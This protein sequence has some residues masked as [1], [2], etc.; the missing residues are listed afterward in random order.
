[1]VKT[2]TIE[3][4][5]DT[6]EVEIPSGRVGAIQMSI[7][8]QMIPKSKEKDKAGNP[9]LSPADDKRISDGFVEWSD[10]VLR[11]IVKSGQ[12]YDDIPGVDQMQI[13]MEL[14]EMEQKK[15]FP[16]TK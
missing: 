1:M 8:S 13:F 2:K 6:Y 11:H 4:Q 12:E 7:F 3:T 9:I 5:N 14:N 15:S 16:K 10:K